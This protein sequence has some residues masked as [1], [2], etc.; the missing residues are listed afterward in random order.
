GSSY[1]VSKVGNLAELTGAVELAFT[2]DDQV[3]VEEFLVGREIDIAVRELGSGDVE[4]GPSL[5]IA[6]PESGFF[7]THTKYSGEAQFLIPAPLREA[8]TFALR[9]T[10]RAIYTGLGCAGIARIDFFLT[11]EGWV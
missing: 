3:L 1:G 10:A 9:E 7:D 4:C 2:H 6:L 11:S 5:E 8:E